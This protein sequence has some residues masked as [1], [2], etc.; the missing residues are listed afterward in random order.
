MNYNSR[1]HQLYAAV[2]VLPIKFTR[3][4][5]YRTRIFFSIFVQWVVLLVK[6][7]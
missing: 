7:L 3:L 1:L 6:I 5:F 4:T 2:I